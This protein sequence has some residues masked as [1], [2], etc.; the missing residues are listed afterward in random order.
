M[1]VY[2]FDA[3]AFDTA[4]AQHAHIKLTPHTCSTLLCVSFLIVPQLFRE[5][6]VQKSI[7]MPRRFLLRTKHNTDRSRLIN[8]VI[9]D[10][11]GPC[12]QV[13]CIVSR[14][15]YSYVTTFV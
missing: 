10:I 4:S 15:V 13:Y 7:K 11:E 9:R 14:Q 2:H 6:E 12:T 5:K 8:A 1:E 3:L